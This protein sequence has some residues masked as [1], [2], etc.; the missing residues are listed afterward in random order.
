MVC[1]A[2]NTV[3]SPFMSDP[4]VVSASYST[5]ICLP[6]ERR[7]IESTSTKAAKPSSPPTG[8]VSY[9]MLSGRNASGR[10]LHG[11]GLSISAPIMSAATSVIPFIVSVARSVSVS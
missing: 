2:E 10:K 6:I 3:S 1:P 5:Y 8:I 7:P 9:A 11:S 4:A